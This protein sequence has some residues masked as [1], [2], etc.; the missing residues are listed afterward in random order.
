MAEPGNLR[1]FRLHLMAEGKKVSAMF[2]GIHKW[3]DFLNHFLSFGM[4][5]HW[6]GV[7]SR[8]VEQIA[9]EGRILDLATGTGDVAGA[10]QSR[11]SFSGK[12]IGADFCEPMLK[13][14]R[15]KLPGMEFV[16]ADAMNLPFEDGQFDCVTIAFGVRNFEDRVRGLGQIARVLKPG[17]TLLVLEFSHPA[18]WF[19]PFYWVYLHAVLP[20]IAAIFC[21]DKGAYEYLGQSIGSFPAQKPFTQI[22]EQSGFSRATYRNLTFGV[23]AL[24]EAVK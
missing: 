3:Y 7:V 11:K 19:R 20:V 1:Y 22:L 12:I 17:G 24:H 13:V 6:R 18:K 14:A 16:Y 5:Y 9:P 4:D 10:I 23:V 15:R 2:G 8:R 21:K